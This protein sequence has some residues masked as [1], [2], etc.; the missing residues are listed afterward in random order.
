M[1]NDND[2]VASYLRRATLDL[3]AARQR[4][5]EL[6]ADPIAI[7]GT[8]CRL[9]GGIDTPEGFWDVLAAGEERLSRFPDDRGW[10][11]AG[12]YH[13]DPDHA[14]TTYVRT[15][16]FLERAGD[17][18]AAFFGISP[19]EA[20]AM[21]PQ[22][23]LLLET[24]WELI[25]NAGLDPHALRG[26]GTGVFLGVAR[27]GY[28]D[29][30]GSAEDAEGYTVTGVAPS[31]ASGRIAY[32]LGLE[33]PAITLDTACSS[34]LVALHLAVAALRRGECEAAIVGGAAVMAGPEVFVDFAR[35]R[36]LA[37]DGRSK[38]FGAA[39]DGFGFGE[40]VAVLF[41]ERLSDA[42]RNGH[43]V[44]AVVHGTGINQDGASNG[45]SAPSRAAQRKVIERAL[46][47][48]GVV[49]GDVDAVEAHGTGTT[50]GDPIEANA[51]LDTYGRHRD[52]RR[53]LWLGSAKSNIGHTQGAAGAVGILKMVLAL[54][55]ERLPR[56][57]HADEPSPH[58]DW[59]SGALALLS[60]EQDWPRGERP[61]YAAVSAFGISGTNAH[62]VIGEAPAPEPLEPG[63]PRRPEA[64]EPLPE[65]VRQGPVPLV[66]SART[67]DALRAQARRLS[68]FVADGAAQL[69]DLGLS[70]ATTRARHEHRAVVLA[71]SRETALRGLDEVAD[72][73]ARVKGVVESGGRS[74]VFLFPG[75]GS[76]WAG[77]GADLLEWSPVFAETLRACDEAMAPWQDWSVTAVL[78]QEPGAPGLDRVDVVQPA[79]FA[80]MVSL[81]ALWRA[82]GV[83]PAAV[84]GHS[85]G[86]IAAAHVAGILTLEDAARLVVLR[87][88][89]LRSVAGQGAMAAVALDESA[90]RDL[91]APYGDAIEVAAVNGPAS[92]VVSG[93]PEA[94]HALVAVCAERGARARTIDVDYA[95]HSAQMDQVR[96]ELA[97][98]IGEVTPARA[99]VPFYSTVTG[100]PMEGAELDAAYWYRNLREPVRLHDVVGLLA[101]AHH[102]AF[103]EIS[104][105]PVLAATVEETLDAQGRE[106]GEAVTVATLRRNAPGPES[107][108]TSV[109]SA[110]VAGVDVRWE[111]AFPDDAR[112]VPLP[113]YAFRRKH[114]WTTS[115]AAPARGADEVTYRAA[116]TALPAAEPADPQGTWLLVT[117]ATAP[118]GAAP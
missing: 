90:V 49:P 105:H 12:L 99:R 79:L 92:V 70:L 22:Q 38:A 47:N 101:A 3:R 87:S 118:D 78:R 51:L 40:G 113:T 54:R 74:P 31:V 45:L 55:H 48:A 8:A 63:T 77:M 6:E 43:T 1:T 110:H 112:R 75:Q 2:K 14:G 33:G 114:Y 64:P 15:G 26:T 18:D 93:E 60:E 83:E 109:A 89:L 86:E 32:T 96:E 76:Q 27:H 61:R 5:Q 107:F 29:G 108:L 24:C 17:F 84:A 25:E 102:D 88:R 65:P 82:Y 98:A 56:T 115:A 80:V 91:L 81:A 57:L 44:H 58:V 30:A 100:R 69:P 41:L 117:P 103:V 23:R 36:A 53:P 68:A 67:E 28:G 72:G 35:Q 46:A 97:D 106:P 19:R 73:R 13:P 59:S 16:A 10:D 71:G 50:L 39:A 11:L 42:R 95:S 62:V 85:Q 34:S 20:A 9:P 37:P 21:D 111:P 116:W 7:V 104:P 4:I 66:V 52:T 94:V